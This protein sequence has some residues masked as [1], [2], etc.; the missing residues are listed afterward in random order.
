MGKLGGQVDLRCALLAVAAL[1]LDLN[2]KS[3]H[4]QVY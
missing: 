1:T 4:N 2:G 3:S